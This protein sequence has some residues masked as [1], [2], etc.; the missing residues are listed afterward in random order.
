MKYFFF[1]LLIVLGI[2]FG[3]NTGCERWRRADVDAVN[4]HSPVD[5]TTKTTEKNVVKV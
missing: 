4:Y 1:Y 5:E 3:L 2:G